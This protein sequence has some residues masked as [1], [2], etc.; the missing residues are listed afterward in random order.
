MAVVE[1][2]FV[3]PPKML[4]TCTSSCKAYSFQGH[5]DN[6]QCNRSLIMKFLSISL[7]AATCHTKLPRDMY[8]ICQNKNT[9]IQIVSRGVNI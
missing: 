1:L 5:Q 8:L 4:V 7:R 9:K 3:I 6:H 2:V